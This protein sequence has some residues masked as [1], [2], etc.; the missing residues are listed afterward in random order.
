MRVKTDQVYKLKYTVGLNL[1]LPSQ[2]EAVLSAT[3]K[4]LLFDVV[5]YSLH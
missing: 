4:Y 2:E 5:I 1:T 3:Q